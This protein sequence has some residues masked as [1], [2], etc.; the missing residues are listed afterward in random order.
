MLE[1]LFLNIFFKVILVRKIIFKFFPDI[2]DLTG[3]T[4]WGTKLLNSQILEYEAEVLIF[5]SCLAVGIL[6]QNLNIKF[7]IFS[8]IDTLLW[9]QLCKTKD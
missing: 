9:K 7:C 8:Q 1:F 5:T 3:G 2:S 4:E 6:K